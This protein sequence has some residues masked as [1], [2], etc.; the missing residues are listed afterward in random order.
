[1]SRV[2][3]VWLLVALASLGF[4]VVLSD[5]SS[6]SM[7]ETGV[8]SQDGNVPACPILWR[9]AIID[10]E[11]FNADTGDVD[12]DGLDDVAIVPD[13]IHEIP[14][15]IGQGDNNTIQVIGSDGKELWTREALL[16]RGI[17]GVADIDNDTYAEVI[18][19]GATGEIYTIGY[20]YAFDHEGDELWT[21][22]LYS[23][24]NDYPA[25]SIVIAFV[26]AD[27][28][29][30]VEMI[31]P[32]GG[33]PDARNQPIWLIDYDGYVRKTQHRIYSFSVLAN[34][35]L[36]QEKELILFALEERIDAYRIEKQRL[37]HID[38]RGIDWPEVEWAH[39]IG[40]AGDLDNDSLEDVVS[41]T[42][43]GSDG[44][45][46]NN[47]VA[48]RNIRGQ[49]LSSVY[50]TREFNK[51]SEDMP[52]MPLILDVNGD[53]NK[54]VLIGADRRVYAFAHDGSLLWTFGNES[55]FGESPDIFA[56]DIDEDGYSETIFQN[57]DVIFELSSDGTASEYCVFSHNSR[58]IT[59]KAQGLDKGLLVSGDVDGDGFEELIIEEIAPDGYHVAVL[60]EEDAEVKVTLDIDPDTLNLKSKGRWITAYLSAQNA[61]LQDIDVSTILLQEALTPERWD[62]QD[63]VLMLKFNRQ[64]LIAMLEVGESVE[65]MLS[66]KWKDGTALEAH[67]RIRVINPEK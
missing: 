31:L 64:E 48:S 55:F 47:L 35:T 16:D 57:E 2:V 44:K 60:S 49:P 30:N 51:T 5:Y 6:D 1:M 61:S 25:H 29:G 19:T 58:L 50:W 23:V 63:D 13:D 26:D 9:V 39:Q 24:V 17:I 33:N 41:V 53:Q 37:S 56:F 40:A 43:Y 38:G 18:A 42:Q 46:V 21:A 34:V 45:F 36:G 67:D 11:T 54:D 8:F 14:Y 12:G 52:G 65:I 62:H 4:S 59:R 3:A 28:D 7:M 10:N 20:A 22:E 27:G 15:A 66:G 32:G